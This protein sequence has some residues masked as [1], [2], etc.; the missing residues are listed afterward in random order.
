MAW[1]VAPCTRSSRRDQPPSLPAPLPCL[2]PAS[3]P[4]S[5]DR[6]SW[7]LTRRDLFAPGLLHAGLHPDRVIYVETSHDRDVLPLIEEGLREKGLGA[8]VGEVTRLGFTALR[9]LQLAA[10]ASGVTARLLRRWWTVVEK[11]LTQLPTAASTR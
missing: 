5:R 11:D 3:Q 7:C 9:R 8:V 10:E 6:C 2:R 1:P 4:G